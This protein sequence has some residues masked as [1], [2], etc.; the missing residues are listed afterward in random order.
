M[1]CQFALRKHSGKSGG[2]DG[3][4]GN[5]LLASLTS[6]V[7]T[8]SQQQGPSASHAKCAPQGKQS[9]F[10]TVFK[11]VCLLTFW[12]L[13]GWPALQTNLAP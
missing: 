5:E 4:L 11:T 10:K 9:R 12:P 3:G 13:G 2:R 6:A 1:A 8:Q 7:P